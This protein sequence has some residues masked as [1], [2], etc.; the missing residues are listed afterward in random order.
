MDRHLFDSLTIGSPKRKKTRK[1]TSDDFFP[2]YAGFPEN[3]AKGVIQTAMLPEGAVVFDPWNGSGTTTTAATKL[4]YD[5]YGTDLNPVM[6]LVARA[7][8]LSF[9]DV[10]N[11]AKLSRKIV[12]RLDKLRTKISDEDSLLQ[13]FEP[14]T[15]SF[16]RN[17]ERRLRSA[18]FGRSSA[19]HQRFN[20]IGPLVAVLYVA[21]FA[22]CRELTRKFRSS[23]P[24]WI[25]LP[26]GSDKK[27]EVSVLDVCS[28]YLAHVENIMNNFRQSNLGIKNPSSQIVVG[29][30]TN[31]FKSEFADLILTSP[32]YCTRIDYTAATRVELAVIEPLL[33][34]N[35]DSLSSEML[36]SIKAPVE[37]IKPN[38]DWGRLCSDF[39]ER[40]VAHPSKASKGYYFRTHLDYF[41]KL[42]RSLEN[43]H[44]CMKTNSLAVFVVQDSYYKE[45]HNDVPGILTEMAE[46]VG[47]RLFRRDDF[48]Q[49][50]SISSIN[51]RSRKYR[52][53]ASA[54]E[55]VICF[56]KNNLKGAV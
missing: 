31:F 25:R 3:F 52:T 14:A 12:N 29:N 22:T 7:R 4:G 21:L 37:L 9:S 32:P 55:A 10:E 34:G 46:N 54:L 53:H 47:L 56:K 35:R 27:I 40:L 19:D 36:G 2:Y 15:A 43:V 13:W 1:A 26:K 30:T 8:N 28:A 42:Y 51:G 38:P 39:L 18:A 11:T 33:S 16:I 6:V 49:K 44:L 45:I 48:V 17:I 23:N 24:T 41:D 20:E 50:N 5:S